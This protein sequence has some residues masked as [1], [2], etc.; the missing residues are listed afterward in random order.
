MAKMIAVMAKQ[1]KDLTGLYVDLRKESFAVLNVGSD[2]A[3]TYIYLEESEDKDPTPW[4]EEWVRKPAPT[5][6]KGDVRKVKE[7][8]EKIGPAKLPP[9]AIMLP[10]A[11]EAPLS[12]ESP[13]TPVPSESEETPDKP[14]FL[15]GLMK[16]LFG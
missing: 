12:T 11:T 10:H 8:I 6:T 9:I 4:V 16:K 14:G 13:S 5:M 3:G 2:A 15:K 1:V 7:E